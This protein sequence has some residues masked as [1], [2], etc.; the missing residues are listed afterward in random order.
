MQEVQ[1]ITAENIKIPAD[2]P[3]DA[4]DL[5]VRNYLEVTQSTGR[6]MLFAGDQ[7]IEHLNEDFYGQMEL[8]EIAPDDADPEHLFRIASQSVIG[9]FAAQAGLISLYGRDYPEVPYLVKMNSKTHLFKSEYGDPQSR[10]LT[11]VEDVIALRE[12]GLN[13]K[14]VGYTV[15]LGSE[16][17]SVMLQ[18]AGRLIAAAHR[19]GLL[20]V[21]WMYPRGK[22]VASEKDPHLVAGACGVA[23]CLGSDFVKV[24][25]PKAEGAD[26]AELL[27]E[28]VVAAGRTGVLTAGGSSMPEKEFI[29]QIHK[30]IYIAGG[31]GNATGRNIHQKPLAQAIRMCNA[32]S[33]ITYAGYDASEAYDVYLGKKPFDRSSISFQ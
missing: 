2:V 18:E 22:A 33:S 29:E 3:E 8:G 31:R 7:K 19:Q 26:S 17:E 9:V 25:Y 23:A 28:G 13:I 12:R 15:Y 20:T 4:M 14:G 24:N 1:K 32:I 6:L 11:T 10:S 5:Y 30:I 16:H 27:K 21:I